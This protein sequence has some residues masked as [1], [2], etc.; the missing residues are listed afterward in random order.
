MVVTALALIAVAALITIVY[1]QRLESTAEAG[2]QGVADAAQ[3]VLRRHADRQLQDAFV[4]TRAT[5]AEARTITLYHVANEFDE[6]YARLAR[7]PRIADPSGR[8][9]G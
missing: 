9:P 6:D 7:A 4:T 2:A 1:R 5:L 8:I 3:T